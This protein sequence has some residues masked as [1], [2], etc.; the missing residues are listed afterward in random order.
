M[1]WEVES[2][3]HVCDSWHGE[4]DADDDGAEYEAV[5][6]GGEAV[7]FGKGV[8]KGSE[9]CEED[10]EAGLMLVCELRRGW[11][12]TYL[13]AVYTEKNATIGSVVSI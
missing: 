3:V 10:A 9:E 2:L 5:L 8:G 1:M 12:E 7:C 6:F 4:K 13:K 11:D